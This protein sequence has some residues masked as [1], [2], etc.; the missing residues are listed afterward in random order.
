MTV[1]PGKVGE[2]LKSYLLKEVHG[3][4]VTRS[5]P[6]LLAE[7]LTDSLAL[8]IIC[9]FG[10]VAFGQRHVAD[11]RRHRRRLARSP[12]ASRATVRRRTAILRL[13]GAHARCSSASP[14]TSTRCTRARTCSWSRAALVLMTALSV[15][16]WF[17]EVLAFYLT[18]VGLGVDGGCDTLLKAAFIL[19]ISTLAAAIVCSRRAAS[20]SPRSASPGCRRRL[21]D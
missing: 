7:R 16:S 15:G 9:G 18:L 14:A 12:S 17:F 1:T 11:R 4:P 8:L 3:T 5:A 6:I 20:A 21:L 19:P 2:W 10:V 13:L